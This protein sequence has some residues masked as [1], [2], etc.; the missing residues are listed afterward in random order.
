MMRLNAVLLFALVLLPRLGGAQTQ[1]VIVSGLGGD[2]KYTQEF[3]QLSTALAKAASERAGLPD[4]AITWLGEATSKKSKWYRGTSTR[5][6]LER[7]LARLASGTSTAPVVLMLIGHGSGEGPETRVSLPGPDMTAADFAR[8]LTAFGNRQLA[9]LNLASASGDMLPIIA[10]RHRVVMTATKSAFERNESRF[11]SH[12]VDALALDGADTDKDG[13]ISLLEAYKFAEVET[14]RFYENEGRL[15][16]E[17][18]QMADEGM[19]AGRFF[20]SSGA[21]GAGPAGGR[22]ATLY[23]ERNVLDEQIQ[24]LK[25]RKSAMSA[26]AYDAELERLLVALANKSK[27]IRDLE[28]GS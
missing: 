20:L 5:E 17:H 7:T 6:N 15:A 9:F 13:R 10:S 16:T 23:Q 24:E 26:D 18:A 12:F 19:L 8:V 4:S 27:E 3:A 21:S 22:L 2:P 28:R 11:A 14:K 1:L 25:Q